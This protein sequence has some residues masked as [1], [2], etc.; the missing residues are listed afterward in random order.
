MRGARPKSCLC[1]RAAPSRLRRPRPG[2]AATPQ[3]PQLR[4][5]FRRRDRVGRARPLA[6]GSR[7][8]AHLGERRGSRRGGGA[9][10][11]RRGAVGRAHWLPPHLAGVTGLSQDLQQGQRQEPRQPLHRSQRLRPSAREPHRPL[12]LSAGVSS[13]SPIYLA[14]ASHRHPLPP[15]SLSLPPT[16]ESSPGGPVCPPPSAPQRGPERRSSLNG[17]E[18]RTEPGTARDGTGTETERQRQRRT[19]G[20]GQRQSQGRRQT[21]RDLTFFP[22]TFLGVSEGDPQV[23]HS[24][25]TF[26]PKN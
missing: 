20:W 24:I 22:Q 18:R 19:R 5:L 6:P 12:L 15:H 11:G 9:E 21:E 7:H 26:P 8:C 25:I 3:A 14:D 2:S 1:S 10:A 4:P 13:G 16:V 23:S 17:G